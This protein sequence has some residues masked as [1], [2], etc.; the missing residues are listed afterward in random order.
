MP[1]ARKATKV[2]DN[3]RIEAAIFVIEIL[4]RR[5]AKP[6]NRS[7]IALR[8]A[9]KKVV[10]ELPIRIVYMDVGVLM[11]ASKVPSS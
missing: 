5:I 2:I 10:S 6:P 8:K 9:A 4:I 11:S 7:A 1:I 3:I